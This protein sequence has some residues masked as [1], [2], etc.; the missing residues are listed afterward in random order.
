MLKTLLADLRTE[1][2]HCPRL[3]AG[4]PPTSINFAAFGRK[5]GHQASKDG[6]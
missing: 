6:G 2:R 4:E 3:V 1:V 5:R